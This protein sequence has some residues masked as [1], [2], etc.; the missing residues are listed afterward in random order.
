MNAFDYCH[1]TALITG[2]SSG[3]GAVYAQALAARGA[4]VV[5]VARSAEPLQALA[6]Q[7]SNDYGVKT[8]V[9][10]I[11]LT[12]RDAARH[13]YETACAA[14]F[15][16]DVLINNAG[17]ATYGRFE[18][19]SLARQRDEIMLNC[20]ALMALTHYALPAMLAQGSG[21][22]VQVASTAAFQPD[23]YMAVYGASKAFVLSFAEAL[24][25]ENH[26]HGVRV[27]AL[28]P[29]ATETPFFAVVGADEASVGK[30]MSAQAV[31]D[32]A[33]A[34]V[35]RGASHVIVGCRNYWLAQVS[36]WLPRQPVLHIV[37]Q[38][39]RPQHHA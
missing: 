26:I 27:L 34:A 18:S 37:E 33:F 20:M 14:G 3:I 22:V 28:C 12:Q 1:K 11:D 36:R 31:V 2:A 8:L 16:P 17:F 21:V 35:D 10:A 4:H 19:V 24:W 23:P 13:V 15:C 6:A 5:L 7:L 39:L 30:R 25:A 9:I 32:T 29:G 38:T